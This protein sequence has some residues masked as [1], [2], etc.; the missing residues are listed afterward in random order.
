MF[1]SHIPRI[2]RRAAVMGLL[3]AATAAGPALAKPAPPTIT[4]SSVTSQLTSSLVSVVDTTSCVA[5]ALVQPF[6][7]WQDQSDYTLAPGESNDNFDGTGWTLIGGA[8][9][10]SETL[11][12]GQTG[13]VLDLPSGSY[14]VSPPMCV[15]SDYP[16]ARTML[17]TSG[18]AQLGAGVFYAAN[19][20]KTQMQLSGIIQGSG[21]GFTLSAP[22]Q[23]HPGNLAGWQQVQF[24]FGATG[25]G[26][27]AQVYNF[28][29]DPRMSR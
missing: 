14:A 6:L 11:A 15:A 18:N 21:S 23:V 3:A 24:L 9:I 4:P 20:A 7:S 5:P 13:D 16:T 28:Y 1:P 8:S 26:G 2:A 10:E 29:V 19:K 12:D 25:T 22:L 27:D 17:Q